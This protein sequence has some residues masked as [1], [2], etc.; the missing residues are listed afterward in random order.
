MT[1][2]SPHQNSW[3][4]RDVGLFWDKVSNLYIQENKKVSKLHNQRFTRMVS[5][6]KPLPNLKILNI[7]SRDSE[8]DDYL[9]NY[10]PK[11]KIINA[12]ISQKLINI[13]K[14]IRPNAFQVKINSYS[15]L[16]FKNQEFNLVISLETLEHVSS[17]IDF[18]SELNRVSKPNGTLILS[19]PPAT[20][21]I[22][23][24]IY[25]FFFGGHGEGPHRFLSSSEVRTILKKTEWNLTL[26]KS[27]LI[28]PFGPSWINQ[29]AELVINFLPISFIKE[30]GIRHFY[31]CQKKS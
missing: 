17:P 19:C 4:D 7:T 8:T 3:K 13:A 11:V 15:R 5:F 12:E 29:F 20:A 16:P 10:L 26:F 24:K 18:L 2:I 1:K 9:K 22:I 25:T 27:T 6:I 31:V 30:L 21:E 14:R 23:Y 28:I